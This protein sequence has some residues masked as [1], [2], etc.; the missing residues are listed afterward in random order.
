M[1]TVGRQ[2]RTDKHLPQR[3]YRR[4]G[5][6]YFVDRAGKWHLLQD[7]RGR[8]DYASA[9][10]ALARLIDDTGPGHTVEQLIARYTAEELGA[11]AE[12]TVRGRLQE[13][14]PLAKVFGAMSPQAIEPHHVWEYWRE[15]G[16]T[17]QA[18]HEIRA[19][20]AL[21]TFARR[22]GARTAPNPCFG[23][24][25]P[26]SRPRDRYV[27]DEEFQ[28]VRSIA[29]P[30]IRYAMELA[31]RCGFDGAT[32][33]MLERK[34]LTEEGI[35]FERP[36]TGTLQVIEWDEELRAVVRELLRLRPQLRRYLICTRRGEPYT[37]DGFQ[38]QW[39]RTMRKAM[40]AGLTR[41]FRFHD[42]RAK[43]A[44]DAAD[45]QSAADRLG[46]GDVNLTRKV[47]RR[48]PRRAQALNILGAPERKP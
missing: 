27:T 10:R 41:R 12:R 45:D 5:V 7:E 14:K 3:V 22:C 47:Y 25:L 11:K 32:I 35:E 1:R 8:R 48:L 21:L 34:H 30:M 16:C 18:R 46:H 15:R 2:R 26:G 17:E 38:A 6:Y 19:L 39:Q 9:L 24:Q 33:R 36:K 20:S 31:V 28:L 43:S 29:Q 44:S 42:L 23:L 37:L 13:F 4:R 40:R